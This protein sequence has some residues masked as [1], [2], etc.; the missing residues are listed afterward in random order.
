MEGLPT[1]ALV[2]F[3]PLVL[4]TDTQ[5]TENKGDGEGEGAEGETREA[6]HKIE[7][8]RSQRF[9]LGAI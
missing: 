6:P 3:E 2:P 5:G 4:W 9:L 8:I 7:V 1:V